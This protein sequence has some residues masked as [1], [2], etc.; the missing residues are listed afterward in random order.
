MRKCEKCPIKFRC[1]IDRK[2]R[3]RTNFLSQVVPLEVLEVF[4]RPE[5]ACVEA[6]ILTRLCG[7]MMRDSLF[8]K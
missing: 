4:N 7:T 3:K 8:V 2:F 6:V 5:V 1:R